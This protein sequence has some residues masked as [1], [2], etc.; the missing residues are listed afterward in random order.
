MAADVKSSAG[1]GEGKRFSALA[2]T[3]CVK[4]GNGIE[5]TVVCRKCNVADGDLS[6]TAGGGNVFPHLHCK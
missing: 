6:A 2:E 1:C 3:D 4:W 5:K